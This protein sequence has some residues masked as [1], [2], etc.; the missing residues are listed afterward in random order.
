LP[1]GNN[2]FALWDEKIGSTFHAAL[3]A[4]YP[5]S[6]GKNESAL[7]WDIVCDLRHGG[8]VEV[9]GNLVSENRRFLDPAWP[10]P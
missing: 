2:G 7:H 8:R 3:G 9:D 5:E 6:S 1:S 10:Q 4:A